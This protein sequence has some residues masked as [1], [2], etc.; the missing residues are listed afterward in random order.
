MVFDFCSIMKHVE[1]KMFLDD[2]KVVV[3]KLLEL[4][5]FV[6]YMFVEILEWVIGMGSSSIE[7]LLYIYLIVEITIWFEYTDNI[8]FK[9]QISL[10]YQTLFDK[11]WL[12]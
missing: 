2:I 4:L 9:F 6:F 3:S 11:D 5:N 1:R 7:A 12:D 10:F 8:L